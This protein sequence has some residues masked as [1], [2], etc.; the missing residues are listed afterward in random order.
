MATVTTPATPAIPAQSAERIALLDMLRGVALL[1]ILLVNIKLFSQPVQAS[2]LPVESAA[3]LAGRL[4]LAAE[5]LVRF[6]AEGKFYSLFSF[7]FGLGFTLQGAGAERRGAR[8][9]PRYLRRLLVLLAIGALHAAFVW[10]G[11]ILTLYALLGGFLLLFRGVRPRALLLWAAGLLALSLLINLLW[12]VPIQGQLGWSE[13][14]YRDEAARAARVYPGGTFAAITAQRL[15]DQNFMAFTGI[16]FAP[17]V[18]AMF[19]I[20]AYFGRRRIFEDLDRHRPLFRALLGWGLGLGLL[21]N[22]VYATLSLSLS[23]A[24]PTPAGLVALAGQAVGVPALCLGYIAAIA[25]LVQRRG[26]GGRLAT[27]APV[28]RMALSNYLG[29]S[30]I[31]TLI[32]YGYGLG[33]F[34]RVGAAP[35]LLLAVAIYAAQV[36]ISGWWLRRFRFGPAEWLWRSLTY[37]APQPLRRAPAAGA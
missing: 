28:G 17:N 6:L 32:F 26:W 14:D 30:L 24:A 5:W 12:A 13:A 25:L 16:F 23:R 2:M 36:V 27:L 15:R 34:G 7:L 20:G 29:Q 11:D 33:L 31:C 18:F 19:L 8:F 37:L 9:L 3:T 22:A 35:G 1:G 21:G 10:V 4:N